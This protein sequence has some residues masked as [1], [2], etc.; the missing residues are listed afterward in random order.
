ML[1]RVWRARTHRPGGGWAS[2]A[3]VHGREHHRHGQPFTVSREA[4]QPVG[5]G[6]ARIQARPS[7]AQVS[8]ALIRGRK[9]VGGQDTN[10][11]MIEF[12]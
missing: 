3:V 2:R 1:L 7:I 10:L 6:L 12:A 8:V 4:L 5:E 11:A 9:L